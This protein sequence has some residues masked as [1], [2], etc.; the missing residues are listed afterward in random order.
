[1]K[2]FYANFWR[3]MK[4]NFGRKGVWIGRF[5][6][7]FV[8]ILTSFAMGLIYTFS[9]GAG[10]ALGVNNV[11]LF[12]LTGFFLQFLVLSGVSLAPASFWEDIRSGSLEFIFNQEFSVTQYIFG[13]Y[14]SQ[15]IIDFLIS[16]PFLVT[17]IIITSTRAYPFLTML[18]FVGFLLLA[19][20]CLFAFTML[21]SSL[22]MLSKHFFGY[23]RV[24]SNIAYFI[25]GVYFPVAS[26][27][28]LFGN[29]GGWITIGFISVLPYTQIFDIARYIIFGSTYTLALTH[30]WIEFVVLIVTSILFYVLALLIFKKGFKKLRNEGFPSYRY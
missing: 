13:M 4:Y 9:S 30:L 5:V 22:Y 10:T 14:L 24:V 1:M 3:E 12:L 11:G 23:H 19:F 25:C 16:V 17:I 15:F 21:Y 8:T 29:V 18:A 28:S 27:L 20:L 26:Y 7:I 2:T 6:N